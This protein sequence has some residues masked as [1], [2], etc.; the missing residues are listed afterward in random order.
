MSAK[1][2]DICMIAVILKINQE[3]VTI[4]IKIK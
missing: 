3:L 2:Y 4:K 1:D